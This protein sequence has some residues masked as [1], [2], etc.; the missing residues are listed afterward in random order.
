MPFTKTIQRHRN[1]FLPI[2]GSFIPPNVW[3]GAAADGGAVTGAAPGGVVTRSRSLR[4]A[5]WHIRSNHGGVDSIDHTANCRSLVSTD[6]V[7]HLD[8]RVENAVY[9][10]RYAA[11]ISRCLSCC[12]GSQHRCWI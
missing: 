9:D 10:S 2:Q 4:R 8:R 11:V 1:N 6:A 7:F 5:F 12:K 3:F